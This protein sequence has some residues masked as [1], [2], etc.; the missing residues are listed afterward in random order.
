MGT[1]QQMMGG[2]EPVGLGLVASFHDNGIYFTRCL[3]SVVWHNFA[4]FLTTLLDFVTGSFVVQEHF[5][6]LIFFFPL[7]NRNFQGFS[8]VATNYY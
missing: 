6:L 8:N 2:N 1:Y 5:L 3:F 4:I 7:P